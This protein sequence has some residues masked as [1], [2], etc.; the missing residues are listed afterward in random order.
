V[1]LGQ[2]NLAFMNPHITL[3]VNGSFLKRTC[4]FLNFISMSVCLYVCMYTICVPCGIEGRSGCW[5]PW[6]WS[7]RWLRH[8]DPWCTSRVD[9]LFW[10][11]CWKLNPGPRQEQQ[12][13][14]TPE[15]SLLPFSGL[16]E[17]VAI[18]KALS[19]TQLLCFTL[20]SPLLGCKCSPKIITRCQAGAKQCSWIFPA[21]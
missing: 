2:I 12:V 9:R 21:S 19:L 5:V 16:L 11:P 18:K 3:W 8:H 10:P 7:C 14:L 15:P 1:E 4:F 6:N 13:L 17:E 20:G